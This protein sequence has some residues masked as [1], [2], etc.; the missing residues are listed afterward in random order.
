MLRA[1]GSSRFAI[2]HH[3]VRRRADAALEGG[4]GDEF[5]S[6]LNER[7]RA[8][9]GAKQMYVNELFVTILRRPLRGRLGW[10]DRLRGLFARSV[11]PRDAAFAA[12]LRALDAASDALVA[13]LSQYAPRVL[14]VY[15]TAGG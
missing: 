1:I 9:L 4:F 2:H 11:E 12:D 15:D 10:A 5:S 8:R 13:A 6:R 7:W 3:V 14:S